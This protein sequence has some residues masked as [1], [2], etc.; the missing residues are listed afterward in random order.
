MIGDSVTQ[1]N[2]LQIITRSQEL[3]CEHQTVMRDFFCDRR[4][5]SSRIKVNNK[6]EVLHDG[7]LRS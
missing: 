1:R 2:F 3:V 7:W 5:E 6:V 4:K